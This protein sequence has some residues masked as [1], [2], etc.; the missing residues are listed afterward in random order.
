[1]A[2]LDEAVAAYTTIGFDVHAGGE[3]RSWGS[4]N[5]LVRFGADHLE[6]LAVDRAR[7]QAADGPARELAR[8]LEGGPQGPVAF[9]LASRDMRADT[10]R[11]RRAGAAM[12][13]PIPVSRTLPDGREL[14]WRLALPAGPPWRATLPFLIQWD[15]DEDERASA[16]APGT[17]PNGAERVVRLGVAVGDL[18]QAVGRYRGLLDRREDRAARATEYGAEFVRFRVGHCHLD[19]LAPTGPGFIQRLLRDRGEGLFS[20]EVSVPDVHRVTRLLTEAGVE[21]TPRI[22]RDTPVGVCAGDRL[23]TTLVFSQRIGASRPPGRPR[24]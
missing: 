24:I 15:Q 21:W 2:E 14:S 1:M 18:N 23:G 4:R 20:L 7:A 17:H 3:H 12:R 8:L 22:G 6:L 13:E 19:L 11:L 10:E 9:V 5:A 16:D